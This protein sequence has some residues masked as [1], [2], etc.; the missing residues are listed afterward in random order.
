[1]AAPRSGPCEPWASTADI[2]SPCDD[3]AFNAADLEDGLDMASGILF[4]LTGRQFPGVCTATV[5]PC[6]AR[7]SGEY[8]GADGLFHATCGCASGYGCGCSEL[9]AVTL[10]GYPVNSITEVKV[11]GAAVDPSL[12]RVDEWRWLVRLAD[13][14]GTNPGWPCAQRLDLADTEDDTFSVAFTYGREPPLTGVRAAAVL[15]CQIALACQ[16]ETA[17][18]C[19]LSRRVQSVTRQGVTVVLDSLDAFRDGLTG[20]PEVDLFITSVNP[21]R[22]RRRARALSPDVGPSARRIGT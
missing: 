5:R 19:Q 12:Y 15:G 8:L 21:A 11:D 13:A 20:I 17:G 2:C 1:M 9:S 22:L 14:D 18:Q 3:Y 10:G 16:P 6:T 7:A 4:E